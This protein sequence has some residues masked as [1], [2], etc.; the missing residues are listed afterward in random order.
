MN[1]TSDDFS[2]DEYTRSLWADRHNKLAD[3]MHLYSRR[4]LDVAE[5]IG[6]GKIIVGHNNRWKDNLKMYKDTKQN[7]SFIPF[8][9]FIEDLKYKAE[10]LGIEVILQEES[11]TSKA[12]FFD[13]DFMPVYGT[14]EA[15][16]FKASGKRVKRG[17]YRTK[18]GHFINADV[19]AALNIMRKY[20]NVSSKA[21]LAPEYMG[22]VMSPLRVRI[23]DLKSK[24]FL[25][26][27]INR[28]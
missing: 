3:I 22:T 27:V 24:V 17:L 28:C 23:R 4:V 14:P 9:L 18:D 10:M 15:N 25:Y 12:S 11:Y 16:N 26:K 13:D 6:A 1:E 21:I 2:S 7:F 5:Y 20:M 8:N 19:N